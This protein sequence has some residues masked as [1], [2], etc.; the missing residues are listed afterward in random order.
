MGDGDLE[1]EEGE[2]AA[3]AVPRSQAECQEHVRVPPL[4]PRSAEVLRVEVVRVRKVLLV[5]HDGGGGKLHDHPLR[6]DDIRAGD[7]FQPLDSYF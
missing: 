2:A 3:D 6:D 7:P 4:L 1:L 5:P